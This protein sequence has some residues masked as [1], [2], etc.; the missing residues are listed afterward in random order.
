MA[1]K[2]EMQPDYVLSELEKEVL[3]NAMLSILA[4]PYRQYKS[5]C[6]QV[7]ELIRKGKIPAGFLKALNELSLREKVSYPFVF[8][9]NLPIDENVP[10]F[11]NENPI[12]SKYQ[13][14]K[15]FIAEGC[16][17]LIG[18][19]LNQIPIGY[20]NVNGGDVFQDI[21][22]QRSLK[23]T[24]S[25][26]ALGPIFFHKDL[27]NHFVRPDFVNMLSMRSHGEN[28]IYTTFVKN[29]DVINSFSEFEI[30]R[31][32]Q[33]KFHTPFD[34][35]TTK[36]GSYDVGEAS[37]HPIISD[38]YDIRYFENRTKG[39]DEEAQQLVELVKSRLH[40]LKSCVQMVAGDFIGVANNYSVHGKEV[41][42][43]QF[44]ELAWER[45]TMKTVNVS[46]IEPYRDKMVAGSDYLIQ[47]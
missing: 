5:F 44:P 33:A 21:Y 27:A 42:A 3:K 43:L 23:D 13:L 37:L 7:E 32:R 41:G 35:L 11:D 20:L 1:I 28:E 12:Q 46:S 29:I 16:L 22:P 8:I 18:K 2:S 25:Q 24:Q 45:W 4:D 15:T 39:I 31:L 38:D 26:K 17:Y 19:V 30:E 10:K 34:D 6:Y 9:K 47:G 40:E 14:K 36:A